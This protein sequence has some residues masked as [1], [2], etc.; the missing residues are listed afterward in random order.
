VFTSAISP[1]PMAAIVGEAHLSDIRCSIGPTAGRE[2]V[3][4]TVRAGPHDSLVEVK[5]CEP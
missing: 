4:T 5:E 3:R 1:F 2:K